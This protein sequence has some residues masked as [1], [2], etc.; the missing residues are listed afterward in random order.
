MALN[1][2]KT[3]WV[4]NETKLNADNMNKIEDGIKNSSDGI[5]A[6]NDDLAYHSEGFV[7][8]NGYYAV[9]TGIWNE[10]T[11]G[12]IYHSTEKI[13]GDSFP[14]IVG[15]DIINST[16]SFISLWL[17]GAYVGR[18]DNGVW[19]IPNGNISSNKIKFDEYAYVIHYT[20]KR[21]ESIRKVIYAN[22]SDFDNS[23][24]ILQNEIEM[25]KTLYEEKCVLTETNDS[26]TNAV[27]YGF[28]C[29]HDIFIKSFIP[30][31]LDNTSSDIYIGIHEKDIDGTYNLV[32]S[33]TG[34]TG[35][36]IVINTTIFK[37]NYLSVSSV[38]LCLTSDNAGYFGNLSQYNG[39]LKVFIGSSTM[40]YPAGTFNFIVPKLNKL[41]DY[42]VDIPTKHSGNEICI[43]NKILC[44]GDSLT[45]G[46]IDQPD[47]VVY[48]ESKDKR[49]VTG[50]MYAY[51]T[52]LNK[53]YG[54]ETVN[55]GKSGVTSKEW[56]E[57]YA[58][59]DLSGYDCAI[60][61]IGNNDY[62]L[63]DTLTEDNLQS[64]AELNKQHTMDIINKIKSDNSSIK[65]FICTLLP[66]WDAGTSLSPLVCQNVRDIADSENNVYLIDL[67]KYSIC[68]N[69]TPYAHGHLTAL[70][71]Y[72]MAK[73]IGGVISKTIHDNPQDFKWVQWIGTG[74]AVD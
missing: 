35:E 33:F 41:E 51:P 72:Q 18:Y 55:L 63:V 22:K 43:F 59:T 10:Q 12:N 42:F 49:T 31:M 64:T 66:N 4:N 28:E 71:Y 26:R 14:Q 30:N 62:R 24:A 45:Q 46:G 3:N 15:E 13:T 53:I 67:S 23:F 27:T 54:I 6:I 5:N 8:K 21:Y 68:A 29:L 61:L 20:Q 48:D 37:G 73:E 40:L 52:Q 70:G 2:Q 11:S 19:Y 60:I 39:S 25:R 7:W 38:G 69:N 50:S 34:K 47:G 16:G 17:S 1:Y 9:G 44:I 65:V 58:S 32:K 57:Q 74:Y 36:E 56:Y